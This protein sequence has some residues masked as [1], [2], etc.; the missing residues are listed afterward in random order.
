MPATSIVILESRRRLEPR[1]RAAARRRPVEIVAT[2]D[3]AAI[4]TILAARLPGWLILEH[5]D[6]LNASANLLDHATRG[7][8]KC[9]LFLTHPVSNTA[10]LLFRSAGAMMLIHQIPPFDQLQAW[11]DHW[12]TFR[13]LAAVR[14][15]S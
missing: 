1:F 11:V 15:P 3:P 10:E 14:N 9:V 13:Q 2:S 8:W 4:P 5:H 7:R 12:A 6:D